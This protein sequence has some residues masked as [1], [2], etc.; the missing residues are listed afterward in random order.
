M[1][2]HRWVR[3]SQVVRVVRN[4][5]AN[6]GGIREASSICGS[7]RSPGVAHGN[8][9]QYSCLENSHGQ[10]TWRT[11][12]YRVAKSWTQLKQLRM[13]TRIADS[14]CCTQKLQ[15]L[16]R[17]C[18][19][20]G[21]PAKGL[22]F[23]QWQCRFSICYGFRLMVEK[24]LSKLHKGAVW[25]RIHKGREWRLCSPVTAWTHTRMKGPSASSSVASFF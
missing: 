22:P 7:G 18:T 13:H 19:A 2:T 14:L 8:S 10:R 25:M 9:L 15:Q 24:K 17:L 11:T 6:A 4:L 20:Q 3:A 12:V 1:Y 23:A 5:P 21:H 16:G